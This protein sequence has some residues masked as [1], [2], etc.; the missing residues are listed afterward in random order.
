MVHEKVCKAIEGPGPASA[1]GRRKIPSQLPILDKDIAAVV[2]V[3]HAVTVEQRLDVT[4][5]DVEAPE[6][7]KTEIVF[8]HCGIGDAEQV[9]VLLVL[10]L[11][12][13]VQ[14][15]AELVC[16]LPVGCEEGYD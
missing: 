5:V 12:A 15:D 6:G 11:D 8:V 2:P 10:V 14:T 9:E 4:V 13:L 1:V 3:P 7:T 16:W